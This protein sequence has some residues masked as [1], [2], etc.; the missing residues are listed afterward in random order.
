MTDKEL[1]KLK[2]SELLELMF[3]LRKELDDVKKENESLKQRVDELTKAALSSKVSLSDENMLEIAK[4]VQNAAEN[5]FDRIGQQSD[6]STEKEDKAA[7]AKRR[8]TYG[9]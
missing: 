8:G 4:A 2:R 5:Y 3:Y 1:R 6:A 9:M 7:G